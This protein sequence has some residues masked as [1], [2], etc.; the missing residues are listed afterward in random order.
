[1][2]TQTITDRKASFEKTVSQVAGVQ[3]E[4]TIRGDHDFT[5]SAEGNVREAFDR[6]ARFLGSKATCRFDYTAD[7]D[8][9]CLY[10]EIAE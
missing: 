6:L 8:L 9:S 1:M 10:V 4:L 5:F 3:V 7:C 2:T